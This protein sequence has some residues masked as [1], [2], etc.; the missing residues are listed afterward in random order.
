MSTD[1]TFYPTGG[2]LAGV[3]LAATNTT[4]D[5]PVGTMVDGTNGSKWEYVCAGAAIAVNNAVLINGSGNA[6]PS[7]TAMAA[8]VKKVGFAQTA[9]ASGSYGWVARS[10]FALNI[11]LAAA[12]AAGVAL[13]TTA[14][15]GVLDDAVV[16]AG[17]VPGVVA[18]TAASAGGATVCPVSAATPSFTASLAPG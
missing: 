12:C 9:I 4:A 1:N 14:T 11:S 10:G 2:P 17:A 18:T 6:F 15:A 7:T 8:S 13:Y 3:N 16:T 5:F